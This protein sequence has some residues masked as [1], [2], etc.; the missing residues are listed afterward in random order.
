MRDVNW[1]DSVLAYV[2]FIWAKAIYR[3]NKKSKNTASV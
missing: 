2:I 1:N 3:Q